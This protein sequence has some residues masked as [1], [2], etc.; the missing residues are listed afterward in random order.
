MMDGL[1]MSQKE[2]NR[3]DILEKT[4]QKRITKKE[5]SK[6]LGISYRH[7]KRLVQKFRSE[8]AKGLIHRNRGKTSPK[9]TPDST[10]DEV[11]RI[12]K[13]R[14]DDF[15]PTFF[16]EK[17]N[18]E[19]EINISREKIRQIL[20]A[21]L[22]WK[23]QKN[24]SGD[25]HTWRER[26]HHYGEMIQVDGS[27]HH[28]LETRL[29]QEICLMGYIDDANGEF[30][31]RFYEYEGTFPGLDSMKE[32]I[33]EKGL[34]YSIYLDRHS[35]YKTTRKASL[36]E[37]L[38]GKAPNT[39]FERVMAELGV[40]VIHARSPQAKGRIERVFD[41][42]QDRLVKEM[43]LADIRT[44]SAAN[45]FL[46][47]YLPKFNK[48]FRKDCKSKV[49]LFRPLP[50]NFDAK[51]TFAIQ[52][53][54]TIRR[55]YTIK[56]QNRLFLI[57]KPNISLRGEKIRIKQALNG[58]LR[59]DTK[60]KPLLVKEI[61]EKDLELMKTN[62]RRRLNILKKTSFPKSKKGWMDKRYI[63]QKSCQLV[64]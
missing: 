10:V 50:K 5:A 40:K 64:K 4:L 55:D 60:N 9:K 61:T 16:T 8:G 54:A 14:Y 24:R 15:R 33:D 23:P 57:E 13:E 62:Q 20:I 26:K 34:P 53:H 6:L 59:F 31:G 22:L 49:T 1:V 43:R 2:I 19:H 39:Q 28:W 46:E 63:G 32:F 29:E 21:N 7:T 37:E 30:F 12:Y 48:Q 38:R 3:I 51:W 58:D 35:T 45:R 27:H 36:D 25:C 56:W 44:I 18:E 11:I 17:L 41:T 47:K 52:D 42:L